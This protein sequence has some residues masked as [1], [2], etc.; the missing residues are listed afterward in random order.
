MTRRK[1]LRPQ[2]RSAQVRTVKGG[3]HVHIR[4]HLTNNE[5]RERHDSGGGLVPER[6]CNIISLHQLRIRIIMKGDAV[7]HALG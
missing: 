7:E 2:M 1:F 3:I 4:L 6:Q 5:I